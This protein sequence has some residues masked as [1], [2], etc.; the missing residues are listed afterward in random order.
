[1]ADDLIAFLSCDSRLDSY[2]SF[3]DHDWV[4]VFQDSTD[5]SLLKR[6]G[7]ILCRDWKG[8][9]LS[10]RMSWM[11]VKSLE[12]FQTTVWEYKTPAP[13]MMM[14]ALVEHVTKDGTLRLMA[15][16]K[17]VSSVEALYKQLD[18]EMRK[19]GP[20]MDRDAIWQKYLEVGEMK[21]ALW[22]SQWLAYG[23]IYFSYENFLRTAVSVA[24][25]KP[26]YRAR[27]SEILKRD[28]SKV[29][30]SNLAEECIDDQPIQI[31][32]MVRNCI[33][34]NGGEET[35]DLKEKHHS[36]RVEHGYLQIFPEDVHGLYLGLKALVL[37]VADAAQKI[38]EFQIL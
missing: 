21:W 11:M 30:G 5:K 26:D 19:A 13:K 31:A 14:K 3:F 4:K 8:I 33:A 28:F 18:E 20:P 15:K 17:L 34:H 37:K 22:A 32:R 12:W 6:A 36:I 35:A 10:S 23:A 27:K 24:K 2:A 7:F 1:M 9:A 25:K 38:P 16:Q 29:F